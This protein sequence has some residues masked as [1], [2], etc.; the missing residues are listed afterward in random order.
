[1]AQRNNLA[2]GVAL[3]ALAVL[4]SCVPALA[5]SEYARSLPA[6]NAR[7]PRAPDRIEV[8]FT[9][10]LFRRAGANTLTVL[11]PDGA[12]VDDEQPVVDDADR[13]HLSVG[14]DTPLPPGEYRVTWRSLS[15][16]D[17]DTAEGS[18]AFTIDPAAPEPVVIGAASPSAGEPQRAP[19]SAGTTR[20]TTR[21]WWLLGAGLGAASS[22]LLGWRALRAP[23]FEP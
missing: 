18:F 19:G 8:W 20:R 23:E 10:E 4:L 21:P 1:V 2:V 16:L 12:R 15:A 6:A 5:H 11:A 7:I 9:Q 13:A 14:I 22:A 3:A 17:G